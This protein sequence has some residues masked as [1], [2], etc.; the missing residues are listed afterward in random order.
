MSL[1]DFAPEILEMFAAT[2]KWG[3]LRLHGAMDSAEEA[4]EEAANKAKEH[5][6]KSVEVFLLS[7]IGNCWQYS[8]LFLPP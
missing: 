1:I 8:A 7:K 5:G 4:A 2:M 3:P 6:L